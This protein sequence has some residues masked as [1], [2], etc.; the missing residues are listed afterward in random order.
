MNRC[1]LLAGLAFMAWAASAQA[2]APAHVEKPK[3]VRN[4]EQ[5]NGWYGAV[6]LGVNTIAVKQDGSS[7]PTTSS[8]AA[9][10]A[11]GAA[12]VITAKVK[13]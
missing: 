10:P 9:H 6:D 11:V 4:A 8:G 5:S 1:A 2:A 12:H 13:H 3:P 7:K